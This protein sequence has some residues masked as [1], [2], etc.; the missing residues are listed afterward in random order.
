MGRHSFAHRQDTCVEQSC[1]TPRASK[2]LAHQSGHHSLFNVPSTRGWMT[3]RRWDAI[4]WVPDLQSSWQILLQCAGPR[5]HHLLRT[6]PTSQSA[7]HAAEHEKGMQ[8][9][10]RALLGDIPGGD[11]EK[12]D[13][14]QLA[15]LWTG[16][17]S[18]GSNGT[19]CHWASW[20]DALPMLQERLP[21][22][23][24]LDEVREAAAGLDLQG[25]VGRPQWG[26]PLHNRGHSHQAHLRSHS[27]SGCSHVLHGCPTRTRVQDRTGHIPR[28]DLGKVAGAVARRVRVWSCFGLSQSCLPAHQEDPHASTRTRTHTR[29]SLQGSRRDCLMQSS[30]ST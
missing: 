18:C 26:A 3:R 24:V 16:S 25:F 2:S 11:Q 23:N 7:H 10:I 27:D 15:T 28:S 4:S 21:V 8:R 5:C 30:W 14:A 13:A 19:S 1:R 20:A 17:Q 6:L 29:K 12:R 22:V 9:T